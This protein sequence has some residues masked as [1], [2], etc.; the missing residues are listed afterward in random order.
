[1]VNHYQV[2]IAALNE[3]RFVGEIE[4]DEVRGGYTFY[5]SGKPH[6]PQKSEEW[7]LPPAPQLQEG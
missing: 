6:D 3:T 2:N 5:C 4:L 7:A 1:M